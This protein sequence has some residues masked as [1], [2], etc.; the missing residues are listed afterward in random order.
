LLSV[1]ATIVRIKRVLIV[2]RV[3]KTVGIARVGKQKSRRAGGIVAIEVRV[4]RVIKVGGVTRIE[5]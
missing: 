3:L 2:E 1:E 5:A 4:V